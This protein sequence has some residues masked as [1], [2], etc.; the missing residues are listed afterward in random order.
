MLGCPVISE[1]LG[2]PRRLLTSQFVTQSYQCR[3]TN[4]VAGEKR[5]LKKIVCDLGPVHFMIIYGKW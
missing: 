2:R 1:D 5:N 3:A 4:S